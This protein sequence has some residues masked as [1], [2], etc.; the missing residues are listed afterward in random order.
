MELNT[1]TVTTPPRPAS[2]VVLL[3]DT[4]SGLEVLLLKRHALSDVLGGAY[5]FPGG[6][7]DDRDA[8]PGLLRHLDRSPEALHAELHEAD[9]DDTTAASL[10][11][12][13]IR[14]AFEESGI[15][16]AEGA[17]HAQAIAARALLH[18]GL[19]FEHV[20][21]RLSL[22]LHTEQVTPWSRWI[23]PKVPTVTNKRFD[24]RFF[25]SGVP[26]DQVAV[27]DNHEATES[28][29]ITPRAALQRYWQRDIELAPPQIMSLSTLTHF[30]D[31]AAVL[32][33]AR[34][35]RPP[36]VAPEPFLQ[37]GM[38]VVCY[39]G[40]ER[41]SIAQ[42]AFPGPTRLTYREGRFEPTTG[43]ES[44]FACSPG[45]FATD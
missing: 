45:F 4:A 15:L 30:R 41:H 28:L 18:E 22:H 16:L 42:R 7:V 34:S 17:R 10:Y 2:T 12:A 13:A 25:V 35:V 5:V 36:V 31:V 1:E 21:S 26:S 8:A 19:D 43:F 11:V 29:W 14:E 32:R 39:P 38:R 24:T 44:L 37:E 6:K 9:I 23:T 27:H 33:H 40:D 20:L 3:R